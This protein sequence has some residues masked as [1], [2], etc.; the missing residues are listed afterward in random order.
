M[1]IHTHD[2]R[3]V[4]LPT[5]EVDRK[6]LRRIQKDLDSQKAVYLIEYKQR[7]IRS[8]AVWLRQIAGDPC[9][10]RTDI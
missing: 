1:K 9:D 2:G 7:K 8:L 6:E 4:L 3:M 5:N 10:E